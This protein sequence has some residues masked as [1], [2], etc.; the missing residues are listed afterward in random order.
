MK[1]EILYRI[2]YKYNSRGV[3]TDLQIFEYKVIRY[4]PKGCYVMLGNNKL[5][6]IGNT[7]RHRYAHKTV[8]QAINHFKSRNIRRLHYLKVYLMNAEHAKELIE[9]FK[10]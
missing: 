4:T 2:E 1:N 7:S 6:Y 9:N 3:R 8:E 5:K 10:P